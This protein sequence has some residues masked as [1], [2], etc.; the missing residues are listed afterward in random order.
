MS[1]NRRQ[2]LGAS[3]VLAG[4]LGLSRLHA[5][6]VLNETGRD[7][8]SEA[9]LEEFSTESRN[10]IRKGTG[11]LIKAINKDGGAGL[12]IGTISDVACTA[13][14]GMALLSQG[15]TPMEGQHRRRQRALMNFLIKRVVS[16]LAHDLPNL[17][18]F[19]TLSPIPGF[20][21]WLARTML[22]RDSGLLNDSEAAA[23][24]AAAEIID[25]MVSLGLDIRAAIHTGEVEARG[26]DIGGLAVNLS[27]RLLDL[28]GPR[29]IL[30]SGAV[31]A[32][33]IGSAIEYEPRGV[34]ELRGVP[35]RW[36]V[37]AARLG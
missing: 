3:A 14:V 31:P 36:P 21:S 30:V 24:A 1:W 15:D 20:R 28:A 35:G 18:T 25:A 37:L 19:A 33:T 26:H 32:I 4:G 9:D 7:G 5:A 17:K 6:P 16:D 22:E 10:A 11:W 13:V 12:D 23:V 34:H 8:V 27:A 29:E 2:L